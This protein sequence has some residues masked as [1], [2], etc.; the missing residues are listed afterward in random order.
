MCPE[1]RNRF[2]VVVIVVALSASAQHRHTH[3]T[4]LQRLQRRQVVT[5][6]SECGFSTAATQQQ[7]NGQI[8]FAPNWHEA[9]LCTGNAARASDAEL[10]S[11]LRS[12]T[13][14]CWADEINTCQLCCEH[15]AAE[16]RNTTEGTFRVC[17]SLVDPFASM[18]FRIRKRNAAYRK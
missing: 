2:I 1:V 15:A 17:V 5:A 14:L 6:W 18:N 4:R 13:S 12:L 3:T 8:V 10:L 16:H 7:Q 9:T 11:D